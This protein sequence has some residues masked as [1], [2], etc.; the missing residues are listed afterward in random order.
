MKL[1]KIFTF[2]LIISSML[3]FSACNVKHPDETEETADVIELSED[4]IKN[5]KIKSEYVVEKPVL[6]VFST[7]GE[8]KRN[9]DMFYTISS[10][11]QGRIIDAPVKL[12]D[13]VKA[14]QVVAYIQ[15]PDIAKINASAT[16]AL[17]E[18]RIAIH[19]AETKYNLAQKNYEREK[20][21]YQ[22]G[23]TARKDLIQA[24]SDYIIAKDDLKI[25]RE[26]DVHIKQET[27]AVMASYGVKPDFNSENVASS[28]PLTAM[29]SGVVTKKNVT[30]GSI[31]TPE[32][33]LYEITD[34]SELWLD[35]IL[36][37]NDIKNI[38]KGQKVE[39][40]PDSMEKV[41]VGKIDYIQPISNAVTQTY[42]ARAFFDNK[43]GLLQP[44]MFGEVKIICDKT[45]NKPFIPK[46]AVQKYGKEIFV[47]LDIGSGKFKKQII[48]ISEETD[49]GFYVDE[50]L[51]TGDK[52]V[53]DGSFTL[54]SEMLKSEFADED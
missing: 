1:Y 50:G 39:F 42:T 54:K 31:V 2:F 46:S 26:R 38:V 27:I 49:D 13:Y 20:R 11:V 32:Q 21:L 33:V 43:D 9:D 25:F 17:H 14:G 41:F 23:I 15:N 51:S 45:I 22:E 52:I 6:T 30:I 7:T 19:Q 29:K 40:F 16:S 4:I 3:L 34:M 10:L 8:V 28:N 47:F 36:Y 35:I 5:S 53:S 48:K 44:G 24:E 18:N 37:S 12:G